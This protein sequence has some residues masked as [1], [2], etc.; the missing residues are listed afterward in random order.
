M[1]RAPHHP[2]HHRRPR[3]LPTL[4][5]LFVAAY[6][7]ADTRRPIVPRPSS[8]AYRALLPRLKARPW[9][10]QQLTAAC[11]STVF[12]YRHLPGKAPDASAAAYNEVCTTRLAALGLWGRAQDGTIRLPLD[13]Q[14]LTYDS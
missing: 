10:T 12:W 7:G 11:Y 1:L 4:L 8:P 3:Y 2:K 5:L 14:V 6:L 9:P 13:R